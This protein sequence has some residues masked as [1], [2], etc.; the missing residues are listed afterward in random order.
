MITNQEWQLH[1]RP[2]SLV[3]SRQLREQSMEPAQATFCE[4]ILTWRNSTLR[5]KNDNRKHSTRATHVS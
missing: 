5:A 3:T 1:L 4:T 2:T